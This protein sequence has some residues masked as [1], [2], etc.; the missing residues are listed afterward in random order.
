M[1][2]RLCL[3]EIMFTRDKRSGMNELAKREAFKRKQKE[4]KFVLKTNI[5]IYTHIFLILDAMELR[6]DIIIS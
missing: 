3:S 6:Y 2:I 1:K 4:E 5:Y